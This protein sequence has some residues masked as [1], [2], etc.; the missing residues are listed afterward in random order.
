MV[1]SL[2]YHSN[3][4]ILGI[5][6]EFMPKLW[7]DYPIQ[8]STCFKQWSTVVAIGGPCIVE[9]DDGYYISKLDSRSIQEWGMRPTGPLLGILPAP[10]PLL[11]TCPSP[12]RRHLRSKTRSLK[13]S[14]NTATVCL[15][16][17]AD[18]PPLN[19]QTEFIAHGELSEVSRCS[20]EQTCVA[21]G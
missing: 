20:P 11:P 9:E 12:T 18:G 3:I 10:V 21:N 5:A 7:R 1:E 4:K 2:K 16:T 8:P 6:L 19:W 13:S 14:D 17:C 15:V